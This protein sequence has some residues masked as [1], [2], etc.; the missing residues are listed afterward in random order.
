MVSSVS[1]QLRPMSNLRFIVRFCRTSARLYH[2]MWL[3]SRMLRLDSRINKH[4]FCTTFP[5][6][7][8]SF[9]NTVPK[10]WNCSISNLFWTLWLTVHFRFASQP[11][12]TKLV[13]RISS[14]AMLVWFVYATKSQHATAQLHTA[15][16]SCNK[17][18]R[19]N[20]TIKSQVWHRGYRT[21]KYAYS[22]CMYRT[23]C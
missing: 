9:A 22:P 10:W 12:K 21:L 7:R 19:Q 2:A 17:V 16:L 15:T 4:C 8:S 1:C 6:S 18:A 14:T 11:T 5:V 23:V 13:A 3:S 20:R